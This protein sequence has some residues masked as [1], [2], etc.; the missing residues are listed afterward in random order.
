MIKPEREFKINN[1]LTLR[2]EN[3]KTIIYITNR[4]FIECK[5]LLINIP[6]KKL[7]ITDKIRNTSVHQL[8]QV[9]GFAEITATYL[10]NGINKLYPEMKAV[11]NTNKI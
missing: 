3:H 11:L 6:T 8:S 10:L 1:Y 5:F 2:L 9:D 4:R 7:G